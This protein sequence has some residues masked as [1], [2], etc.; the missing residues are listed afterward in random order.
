MVWIDDL[1]EL[2]KLLESLWTLYVQMDILA[3]FCLYH[4]IE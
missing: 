3:V 4:K 2:A 1:W